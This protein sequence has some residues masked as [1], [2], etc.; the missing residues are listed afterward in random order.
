M[1]S[2][3]DAF[4]PKIQREVSLKTKSTGGLKDM[5]RFMLYN[6]ILLGHINAKV[7]ISC[8]MLTGKILHRRQFPPLSTRIFAMDALN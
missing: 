2:G 7:L 3:K 4:C 1:D 5:T 6:P 8:A